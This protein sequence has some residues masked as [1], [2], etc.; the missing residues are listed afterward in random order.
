MEKFCIKKYDSIKNGYNLK[1]GGFGGKHS[2]ETID[3]MRFAKLNISDDTRR[4]YSA[5]QIKR[6]GAMTADERSNHSGFYLK[7][8]IIQYDIYGNYIAE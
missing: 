7:K 8:P 4:N 6:F 3:K 1:M 5:G 2:K